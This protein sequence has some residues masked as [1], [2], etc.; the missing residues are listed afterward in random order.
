MSGRRIAAT[1]DLAADSPA[2]PDLP[3]SDLLIYRLDGGRI[4]WRPSGTEPKLKVYVE[5]VQAVAGRGLAE[6]R[7]AAA[8]EMSA[9]CEGVVALLGG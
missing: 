3:R 5:V 2:G 7:R 6:A 1:V 9:L 4:A 8:V